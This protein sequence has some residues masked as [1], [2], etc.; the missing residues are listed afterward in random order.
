MMLGDAAV[1]TAKRIALHPGQMEVWQTPARFKVIVAGRRW[2]K[3]NYAKTTILATAGIKPNQLI[4][5]VAPTYPMA[6]DIMWVD[7]LD[8]VPTQWIQKTNETKM[9]IKL[10]NGT[11][12]M[13][14]GAD[15]PDTLRG[16]GLNYVVL[17]EFQDMSP[18]VWVKIIRPTL[19]TTMG[20]ATFI[21]TPKSFN[22]LYDLYM[23]G[24]RPELQKAHRWHSWQF[25]SVDSPF[26]PPEEIEQA[27]AEMDE[28]SFKQEL[29]ASFETMGGRVY[30]PF[31]RKVHVGDYR[32]NPDLPLWIGQDFNRDPMSGVV[33]Q[34]QSNGEVWIVD[35]IILRNSSTEEAV[36]EIERR[37][38]RH[39]NNIA[40]FPDPAGIYHQHARGET[41]LDIFRQRGLN[42]IYFR[43]KHPKV[44]DRV[45][46]VNRLLKAA[47]GSI[48]MR[49]DAKC[50]STI[51]SLE[52][53]VYKEGSR[54]VDKAL[55]MEHAT[56]ALG[57]CIEFKFPL[58]QIKLVGLN[59]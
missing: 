34:L 32:F 57:Y 20:K 4:W 59:L 36:N 56:D 14:K 41:D 27:R 30:Y 8:S 29:E 21:G 49:V 11:R 23:L 7:L 25:R 24:Q 55:G 52:Q 38:W 1:S 19:A 22:H 37:Y 18:D 43:R 3:T 15:N 53:T 40:M 17:D 33:M 13:C 48:K 26:V 12:I 6:K 54:E 2:G 10:V 31:D 51:A 35:E 50:K 5:Y 47:D 42:R 28:K 16:V 44:A 45:N 46:C 9:A 58:R 39:L